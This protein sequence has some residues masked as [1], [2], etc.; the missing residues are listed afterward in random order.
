MKESLI[1]ILDRYSTV[2]KELSSATAL[3]NQEAYKKITKEYTEL[4][5]TA[6]KILE[7]QSLEKILLGVQD[8]V[9]KET[10]HELLTLAEE[11]VRDTRERIQI[12]EK[13]IDEMLQEKDPYDEKNIIVEIRAGTGGDESSLFCAELFRMYGRF[14]EKMGWLAKILSSSPTDLGG[15]KEIIFEIQGKG[16][17]GYMKYESGTHRVQR[18]P[19]TEKSGRVHTSAATVAVLPEA[20]E[21][22]IEIDSKDLRIDVY[23][24]GGKGGQ[25][26]NRTDSA[27]RITHLPTN[28]VVQCQDERSQ[29]QNRIKAMAVLRSRLLAAK[30]EKQSKERRD[31]RKKQIGTGDRSEKIRTYNFPQ[32]RI[33]DHRIKKSWHNI[34]D[35]LDGKLDMVIEE[36]MRVKKSNIENKNP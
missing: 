27:V 2:E 4:K 21:V 22:D 34:Q 10:D 16:A 29:L 8:T 33:T 32:D 1:K 36:L 5:P 15:F 13:E 31:L 7:L 35:I 17:Y 20:E 25:S 9:K 23:R 14:A 18:I 24:A 19:E 12:L 3:N 26:V 6:E 28:T 11:E 30:I